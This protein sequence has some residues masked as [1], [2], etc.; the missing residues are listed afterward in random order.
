MLLTPIAVKRH[1]QANVDLHDVR[2]KLDHFIRNTALST[3]KKYMPCCE[4]VKEALCLVNSYLG[5]RLMFRMGFSPGGCPPLTPPQHC[6]VH[7]DLLVGHRD[8]IPGQRAPY[9]VPHVEKTILT[10]I[11]PKG[12]RG[13]IFRLI[14]CFFLGT[15]LF[16]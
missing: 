9:C 14:C 16:Q 13:F 5:E 3:Q 7:L 6:D 12:G 4:F 10:K 11:S 15:P 1:H 8:G 2:T